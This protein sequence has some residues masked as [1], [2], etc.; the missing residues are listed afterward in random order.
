ML[1]TESVSGNGELAALEQTFGPP[2]CRYVMFWNPLVR[3]LRITRRGRESL[4]P[5]IRCSKA[6]PTWHSQPE[7]AGVGRKIRP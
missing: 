3:G 1:S 6:W 5:E 2:L 4:T 7:A